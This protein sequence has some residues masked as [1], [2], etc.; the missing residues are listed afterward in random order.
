M[1]LGEKFGRCE[2]GASWAGVVVVEFGE[3]F[4]VLEV[5]R[6]GG[7]VFLGGFWHGGFWVVWVCRGS[8]WAVFEGLSICKILL[9]VLLYSL[10]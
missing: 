2:D 3:A 1:D 6:V 4:E 9:R 8:K 10:K 5:A 7:G